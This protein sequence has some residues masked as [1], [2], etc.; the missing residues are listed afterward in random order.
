[1]AYLT[2]AGVR[3][4]AISRGSKPILT[5]ANGRRA[6]IAIVPA[7]GAV[8]TV[9]AGDVLHG[10][11]CYYLLTAG[12]DF[13]SSLQRASALASLSCCYFGTRQWMRGAA[14]T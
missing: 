3:F 7:S 5:S 6:E 8:D 2:R 12:G 9:G 1:M 10:A 11:F 14:Q 13:Q 4:I